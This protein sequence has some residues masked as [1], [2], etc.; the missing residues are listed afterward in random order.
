MRGNVYLATANAWL[1]TF[2][3]RHSSAEACSV[4]MYVWSSPTSDPFEWTTIYAES[5]S[6]GAGTDFIGPS[7]LSLRLVAGNYYAIGLGWDC[8][9]TNAWNYVPGGVDVGF[10]TLVDAFVADNEYAG[11]DPAYVPSV[12]DTGTDTYPQ[13]MSV[14]NL[15]PAP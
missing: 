13:E 12:T 2:A 7:G 6:I 8:D 14:Y 15:R 5:T 10:G 11:F 1:E 3:Q 9:A 4:D